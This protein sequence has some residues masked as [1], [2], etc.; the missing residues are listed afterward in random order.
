MTTLNYGT[1]STNEAAAWVAYVNAQTNNT[2]PLGTD[3]VGFNWRTAG[4]WALLCAA[5]PLAKDDG[6]NFLRILPGGYHWFPGLG[7]WQ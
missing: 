6:E 7:S 3:A 5:K 1:G 4:Y 2:T